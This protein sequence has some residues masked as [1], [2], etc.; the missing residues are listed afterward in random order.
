M[1]VRRRLWTA[2]IDPRTEGGSKAVVGVVRWTEENV[3][4]VS[5]G[6]A[7]GW[8]IGRDSLV[9]DASFSAAGDSGIGGSYDGLELSCSESRGRLYHKD[10][11]GS[12]TRF[13]LK[14]K[15]EIEGSSHSAAVP[16]NVGNL[17]HIGGI[18]S[19]LGPITKKDASLAFLSVIVLGVSRAIL[20]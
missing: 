6:R 9:V 15:R 20:P 16:E 8:I 19:D 11:R 5:D 10:L 13:D 17:S 1:L 7:R 3:R 2:D 18:I 4:T 14:S 12:H